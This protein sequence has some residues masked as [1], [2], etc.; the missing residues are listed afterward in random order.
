MIRVQTENYLKGLALGV[1][2]KS[3]ALYSLVTWEQYHGWSSREN[4]ESRRFDKGVNAA[5]ETIK[6]SGILFLVIINLIEL[7]W[8][9]WAQTFSLRKN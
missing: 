1:G 2:K 4:F 5:Y 7:Y 8:K 9:N 3:N 6:T